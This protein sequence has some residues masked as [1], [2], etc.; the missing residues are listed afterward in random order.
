MDCGSCYLPMV[1]RKDG[2]FTLVFFQAYLQPH[3]TGRLPRHAYACWMLRQ[4]WRIFRAE[5]KELE[6][7]VT[8]EVNKELMKD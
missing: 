8:E 7:L 3:S 5:S 6:R 2:W 1:L 4:E